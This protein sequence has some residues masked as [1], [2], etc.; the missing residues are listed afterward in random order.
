[1][2]LEV[3]FLAFNVLLLTKSEQKQIGNCFCAQIIRLKR[4]FNKKYTYKIFFGCVWIVIGYL[5]RI[6][7]FNGLLKVIGIQK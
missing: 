3:N 1:M 7:T 5:I 6:E 2:C 4:F